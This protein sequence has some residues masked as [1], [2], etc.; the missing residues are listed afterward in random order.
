MDADIIV[1]RGVHLRPRSRRSGTRPRPC[2][3]P[4]WRPAVRWPEGITADGIARMRVRYRGTTV[5]SH[6]NNTAEVKAAWDICCT[7]SNAA[8]IVAAMPG[9]LVIMTPAKRLAQNVAA[10]VPKKRI[11]WWDGACVVHQRL[12]LQMSPACAS[13]GRRG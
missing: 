3:C 5:V 11:V 2:R 10:H 7:S 1:Q 6:V 8:Q 12:N 13:A 4:T 9:D